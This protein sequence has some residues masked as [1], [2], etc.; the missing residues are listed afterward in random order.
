M[1]N[2]L[3]HL[4]IADLELFISAAHLQNLGKAASAHYLS[5][6]AASAAIKRVE[7]AFGR[8]LCHHEKKQFRLT[9]E[10][11]QL[12]GNIEEWLQQFK[13]KIACDIPRV[14]RLATTQAIARVVIPQILKS[15]A[16]DLK[17]L[18]PDLAYAALIKDETD[19]V[20]VP[21]NSP[22]EDVITTEVHSGT[23]G[24]YSSQNN[25]P[26]APVLLPENQIEV[27][28]LMQRWEQ[29]HN[30]P[31]EIKSRIP[32]WSLIA[33][34]C[35]CSTEIGFLPDFLANKSGL[36]SVPWQPENFPSYSILALHKPY[37]NNFQNRI[38]SLIE[39]CQKVFFNNL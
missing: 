15:E 18:R 28:C 20:L 30:K 38:N 16:V 39:I 22:W 21:D 6:S 19:L 10:G 4:K 31:L 12:L 25:A 23:F 13:D 35:D 32:S 8:A 1:N 33:D 7:S 24:L 3:R 17:L 37:G 14:I 26:I 36:Y 29:T 34:L 9:Q 27:L 2:S 11:I 5:Q